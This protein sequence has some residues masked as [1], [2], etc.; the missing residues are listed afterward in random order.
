MLFIDVKILVIF[1]GS[2]IGENKIY[3]K[4]INTILYICYT[5]TNNINK[6]LLSSLLMII[7][8]TVEDNFPNIYVNETIPITMPQYNN[9]YGNLW[10]YEYINGGLGGIIIVQGMDNEFLAYDRACTN[11]SNESCIISGES[12]NDP[13]LTCE[14]C[15]NSQFVIIDGSVVEGPANQ[16]LKKYNTYFDGQMLYITN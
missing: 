11:E 16:A 8:C 12:T 1:N 14:N 7:S 5:M 13:I 15:C 2:N 9:I 4:I 6:I 10:G 3:T